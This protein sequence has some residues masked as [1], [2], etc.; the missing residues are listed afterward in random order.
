MKKIA[1]IMDGWKRWFTFAWP[2]GILQRIRQTGEEVSLYIFNSSGGWSCDEE[3]N[4]GEYNIYRLP[5][6]REFDGIILDLN[7]IGYPEVWED[8]I[9]RAKESGVPVISIANEIEDFYYVGINNEKAMRMMIEHLYE[10]HGCKKY[11]FVMGPEDNYENVKRIAALRAYMDE[12]QLT[13]SESDFYCES[14]EYQCGV[15][16]F[17]KLLE[18]H[19][20]GRLPQAIICGNDN[21]AVGVC[22]AATAHGYQ[23]PED[24]CVTGFDNFDKAA[25]YEPRI[26]TISHIRENVGIACVDLFLHIWKGEKPDRFYYTDKIIIE[27]SDYTERST[28]YTYK[29][30][31]TDEELEKPL[32]TVSGE[33]NNKTIDLT[34]SAI[35]FIPGDANCDGKLTAMDAAFI[36]KM[37][38]EQKGN[39][40]PSHADF[41][42]RRKNYSLRRCVN[43]KISCRTKYE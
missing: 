39:E 38:A 17:E 10:K 42:Q 40:L 43:C 29:I 35:D 41:K 32:S 37:L 9:R 11:W 20:K 30:T 3:Y 12:K 4:T 2:A 31:L 33:N 7:N 25:Y 28:E 8:V 1:L 23:V 24:F 6:L 26:S 5:D 18:T 34:F 27:D 22:E 13:Y 19:D 21:I 14:F 16:G 15:N 36:A